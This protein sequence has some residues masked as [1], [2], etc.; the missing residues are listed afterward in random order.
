MTAYVAIT[1]KTLISTRTLAPD[2]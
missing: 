1:L 2:M